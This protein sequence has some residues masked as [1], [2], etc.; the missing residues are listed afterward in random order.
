MTLVFEMLYS[1][2]CGLHNYS[3]EILINKKEKRKKS[4]IALKINKDKYINSKFK[5]YL[6]MIKLH[7]YWENIRFVFFRSV[8]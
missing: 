6:K 8:R 1:F 5:L 2:A 3:I 4:L 7:K